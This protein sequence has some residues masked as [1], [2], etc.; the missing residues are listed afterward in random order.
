MHAVLT[1]LCYPDIQ[2]NDDQRQISL[3]CSI[4]EC[5][6]TTS[7]GQIANGIL[8]LYIKLVGYIKSLP[9]GKVKLFF[10]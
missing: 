6:Y 8:F 9:E 3:L 2:N 4:W 5:D 1:T 10:S 7:S